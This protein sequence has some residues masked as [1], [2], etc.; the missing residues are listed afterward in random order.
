MKRKFSQT[1]LAVLSALTLTYCTPAENPVAEHSAPE[2]ENPQAVKN[3]K[4]YGYPA[5]R[6]F[7]E[8]R[9][10]N[11]QRLIQ[12]QFNVEGERVFGK[13]GIRPETGVDHLYGDVWVDKYRWLE[14]IDEIDQD[15]AAETDADRKRTLTGTISNTETS[16]DRRVR[17]YLA[18][19]K[20]KADSEVNLWVNAQ[21]KATE[22]YL[23]AIPYYHEVKQNIENLLNY[24]Y[25]DRE[26][27]NSNGKLRSYRGND[28]YW[29][30]AQVLP[31]GKEKIVFNER[32]LSKDGSIRLDDRFF[33]PDGNLLAVILRD[34]NSDSSK[35]YISVYDTRTGEEKHRIN[36]VDSTNNDVV[37][38]NNDSFYYIRDDERGWWS[39]VYFHKMGSNNFRDEMVFEGARIN[40]S[41]ESLGLS[42]NDKYLIIEA[43]YGSKGGLTYLRDLKTGKLIQLFDQ[44]AYKKRAHDRDFVTY[45]ASGSVYIDDEKDIAYIISEENTE[46]GELFKVDIKNPSKRELVIAARPNEKLVEAAYLNG[47][48]ALQYYV[49]GISK[50]YIV[51][52]NGHFVKEITPLKAA[53][54]SDLDGYKKGD[55]NDRNYF[56][57][58]SENTTTP[59]TQFYFD[60]DK[61]EM[62]DVK[63]RD[64]I[65]FD[66]NQYETKQVFY[67]SKDGTKI[68]LII[69]HKKGIKMDGKNPTILYGYGGFNIGNEQWFRANRAIWLEHGGIWATAF[70]RGGNE[71]G[72]QWHEDGKRLKKMN[73]FDDFIAG[74]EYLIKQG[75]TDKG[76]IGSSGGSNG[77]LLVGATM[78]LRPDLFRTAIPE[79]GVLDMFR[80]DK[81]Y[82]TTYWIDEY[83][84]TNESKAMYEV[85]KSYSPYQNVKDGVC[86][87]STLVMTSKRDDRVTPAHSYKFAA[88]LQEK[89]ACDRPTFLYAAEEHGHSTNSRQDQKTN[90]LYTTL[91]HLNEMGVKSVPKPPP[92][93]KTVR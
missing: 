51:T 57:F 50:L 92:H 6:T 13:N 17:E 62:Y 43:N 9:D 24:E 19:V 46:K 36:R 69:S 11:D 10:R 28:Y 40:A 52:E 93:L 71:Y 30:V 59:R 26:D 80:H 58:R 82:K 66:P 65:R 20:P 1:F 53:V 89:Q 77:G 33:S 70:L 86:Y 55:G 15:Y 23:K 34:H 79:V 8:N 83:G 29:R 31:N 41:A 48:F 4:K 38:L 81:N 88:K 91:F 25:E 16:R 73:V 78:V 49:D 64:T 37:W 12:P 5:T 27:T 35:T 90:W 18:K 61:M 75:Y 68:P 85:L 72:R 63:R 2:Q 54:I 74:A 39:D 47:H 32:A 44:S 42:D 22:D 67:T 84:M 14:N 60:V 56:Y 21:R 7:Q 87:P 3:A 76:H 45:N